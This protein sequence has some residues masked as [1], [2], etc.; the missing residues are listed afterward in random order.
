MHHKAINRFI[1]LALLS[2]FLHWGQG[3]GPGDVYTLLEESGLEIKKDRLGVENGGRNC[4]KTGGRNGIENG[5]THRKKYKVQLS[6]FCID[7]GNSEPT[8]AALTSASP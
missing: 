7:R 2:R 1:E 4:T 6:H 8:D 5:G 3:L